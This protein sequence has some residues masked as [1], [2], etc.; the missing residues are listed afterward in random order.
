M[1]SS[2]IVPTV[3]VVALTISGCGVSLFVKPEEQAVVDE[4]IFLDWPDIPGFSKGGVRALST[5]IE[6]RL[7]LFQRDPNDRG[8]LTVCAEPSAEATQALSSIS[9]LETALK[10]SGISGAGDFGLTATAEAVFRRS[11]GLQFYRDGAYKLCQA[12]S[13]N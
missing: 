1:R 4:L 6:R 10:E 11:Q 9:K 7:V 3:L 8:K 13:T 5:K 12:Y 2:Y